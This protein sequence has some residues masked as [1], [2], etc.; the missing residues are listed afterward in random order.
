MVMETKAMQSPR[1][2]RELEKWTVEQLKKFGYDV[3]EPHKPEKE[4]IGRFSS[5]LSR[6]R[7]RVF[8][9]A[10]CNE[11]HFFCT[12]TQDEK[13]RDR[14]DLGEFRKDFAM[15]VRNLNRNRA[16]GEKIKY[17]L[18]PEKHK[19]GAWHMHGLLMGLTVADLRPFTLDEKLPERI[20]EKLRKGEKIFDWSAY[21]TRFGYFTC[22]EI[23]SSVG[24]AKYITKYITKDMEKDVRE[25]GQHLFF[26]SQGLKHREPI[27]TKCFDKCPITDWD[28]SNKYVMTKDIEMPRP[29]NGTEKSS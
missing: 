24:C 8:E 5:S 1:G 21:R 19:N 13:L 16:E 3:T 23:Q 17:L 27:V 2:T 10:M 4:K 11:F 18:I 7:Q 29:E 25:A 14:F 12:F 28:F 15:L 26:A 9:I 20:R 22:T 6:S